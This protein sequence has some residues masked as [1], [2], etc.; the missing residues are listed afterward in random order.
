L[1]NQTTHEWY[2][3]IEGSPITA[4]QTGCVG[5]VRALRLWTR[6]TEVYQSAEVCFRLLVRMSDQGFTIVRAS[7]AEV[8][9]VS[10]LIGR[11]YDEYGLIF[12]SAEELPDLLAFTR[13]Y[14][15]PHGIFFVLRNHDSVVGSVGIERLQGHGAEFHRL[16]LEAALRGRGLG[17]SLVETGISWCRAEGIRHLLLWTDTRF[18][19]A[20]RLYERMGFQ[21]TGERALHDINQS[22]E[23]RYERQC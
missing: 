18:D 15:A 7:A 21:R 19:R 20:H 1:L 14:C 6:A 22:R 12:D 5:A 11:V 13:H 17:R 4:L 8:P 3:Q 16:Y 9:A 10:S 23:Y 2:S